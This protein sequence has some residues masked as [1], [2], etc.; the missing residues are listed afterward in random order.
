MELDPSC[1]LGLSI[2]QLPLWPLPILFR[3]QVQFRPEVTH[4]CGWKQYFT[5]QRLYNIQKDSVLQVGLHL[6]LDIGHVNM[7][8]ISKLPR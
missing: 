4:T 8:N 5:N 3:S 6:Y 7:F 2:L 1:F